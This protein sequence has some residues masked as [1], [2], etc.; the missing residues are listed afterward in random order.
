M[1]P[2]LC[3]RYSVGGVKRLTALTVVF[4]LSSFVSL[5]ALAAC[6]RLTGTPPP[7][8]PSGGEPTAVPDTA[9][10]VATPTL[11]PPPTATLTPE[12]LAAT[13]NGQPITLA[14]Y[15]QEV[16]RCQAGHAGAGYDGADCPAAALQSLIEQAVLEQTAAAQGV[17]IAPEEL[18]IAL[19]RIEQELGGPEAL[20]AWE[21]ANRYTGDDFRAA[22]QADLLRARLAERATQSLPDTAEHVHARA[23]LVTAADT[24]Q[25]VLAELQAGADFATVALNY[26]R[27]LSSRAAGGDLGWFPRGVLTV[28]EVEEAAFAL[29]PGETSG[30]VQSS[31]G[32]H[33]VQTIERDPARSLGPAAAQALRA[34]AFTAWLDDLVAAAAIERL[35][36]P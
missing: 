28:P 8:T 2:N 15:N 9:L 14:A 30:I 24:A 10:P 22:L 5:V 1:L 25:A 23:V 21:S 13:V 26:S 17:T 19:S 32:F 4:R 29:Q 16:A 34:A 18:Q 27:D 3:R 12:P 11:A 7:V 20:A 6:G 35:V 36:S 33:I 31:L